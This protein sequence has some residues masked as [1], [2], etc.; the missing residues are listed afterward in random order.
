MT[1][2]SIVVTV[3]LLIAFEGSRLFGFQPYVV[4]S[5]SMEP[6]YPVGSLIYVQAVSPEQ[7]SVGDAITFKMSETDIIATH[8]VREIDEDNRQFYTQGINNRDENGNIIPDASP[9]SF[10]SL[11]GKPV[12]CIP[13]LGTVNRFCTTPPGMYLLLSVLAIIVLVNLLLDRLLPYSNSSKK[14]N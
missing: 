8:Q 4:T 11:V 1:I 7:V 5:G 3:A 10:E 6:E 2:V 13:Y 14:K 9:V 12:L